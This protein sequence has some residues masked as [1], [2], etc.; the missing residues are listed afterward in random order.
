[1]W[2]EPF[3]ITYP[4]T[5]VMQVLLPLYQLGTPG[6]PEPVDAASMAAALAVFRKLLQ[7]Q[8]QPKGASSSTA[9][10]SKPPR[11]PT[12][13]SKADSSIGQQ[14]EPA[15]AHAG[16]LPMLVHV[17]KQ[18]DAGL[19]EYLAV[20]V[21]V[22]V[23]MPTPG[24]LHLVLQSLGGEPQQCLMNC[25]NASI[26]FRQATPHSAWQLLPPYSATA[27]VL[28]QPPDAL[29]GLAG[30]AADPLQLPSCSE[31]ILRDSN[32]ATSGSAACTFDVDSLGLPRTQAAKRSA[33]GNGSSGGGSGLGR[34][35]VSSSEAPAVFP[36]QGGQKQALA[37]VRG[38]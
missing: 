24:C 23:E 14:Q 31:V 21:N 7:P 25:T 17:A 18:T 34:G 6:E 9:D 28:L 35:V 15:A 32:P 13:S 4:A 11:P 3:K 5:G 19:L 22:S 10:A 8:Q 1:M 33:T 37:Q 36:V 29:S 26:S 2:S 16:N 20:T 27:L 30:G 12:S 38:S